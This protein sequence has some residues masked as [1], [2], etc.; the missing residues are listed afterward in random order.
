MTEHVDL[1]LFYTGL[2]RP[3][4]GAGADGAVFRYTGLCMAEA[5]AHLCHQCYKHW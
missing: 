4:F 1:I 5:C 3:I 2:D